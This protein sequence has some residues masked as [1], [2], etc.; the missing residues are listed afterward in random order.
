MSNLEWRLPAANFVVESKV[1]AG[2]FSDD[3]YLESSMII[4]LTIGWWINVMIYMYRDVITKC[5]SMSSNFYQ[6]VVVV[7]DISVKT[8]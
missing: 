6:S 3:A 2:C 7:S 8:S 1:G 4:F 5:P